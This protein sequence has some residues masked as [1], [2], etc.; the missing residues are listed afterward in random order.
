[1]IEVT[2]TVSASPDSVLAQ[3][4]DVVRG[5]GGGRIEVD[6]DRRLVAVQGDWWYRGE[7]QVDPAGD[8]A[9]LTHRVRNVARRGRWAVPL[10]NGLFI[11]YRAK[12]EGNFAAFVASLT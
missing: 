1:M 7:Y 12:T 2:A 6:R 9:R 4:I 3:V 10:A 11:G 8:G 5:A